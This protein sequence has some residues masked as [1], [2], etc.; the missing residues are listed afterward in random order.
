VA[1]VGIPHPEW[2]HQ[3][4]AVVELEDGWQAGDSLAA[5]L[6]AHCRAGLAKLKCPARYDFREALPRTATGKLLRR[7][8]RQEMS[9]EAN[10]PVQH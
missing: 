2:G 10:G 6:D 8:I 3:V 9:E 1:V 7:V 5:E 4:V